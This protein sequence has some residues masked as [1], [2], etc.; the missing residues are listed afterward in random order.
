MRKSEHRLDHS[1]GA[2]CS[3]LL[4]FAKGSGAHAKTHVH[5]GPET[6][7]LGDETQSADGHGWPG[8][9]V[10][11]DLLLR[12][13]PQL[14]S[15]KVLPVTESI[16]E[17][18]HEHVVNSKETHPIRVVRNL[19]HLTVRHTVGLHLGSQQPTPTRQPPELSEQG[20]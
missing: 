6:I 3:H 19:G 17:L 4:L 12:Q 9:L 11:P 15:L 10:P 7:G 1:T 13:L 16:V 14:D 2:K 5:N 20:M 18:R 8:L